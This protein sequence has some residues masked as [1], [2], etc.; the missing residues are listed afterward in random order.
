M[1]YPVGLLAAIVAAVLAG[2]GPS[3]AA[4]SSDT[5]LT[6]YSGYNGYGNIVCSIYLSPSTTLQDVNFK[7]DPYGCENDDTKSV[8]F[9]SS[10]VDYRGVQLTVFN[11]SS[12]RTTS[13]YAVT[14]IQPLNRSAR[15]NSF[16]QNFVAGSITHT[17]HY[18]SG[19][20]D[21][22]VSCIRFQRLPV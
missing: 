8:R 9:V 22:K 20:L 18:R 1:L 5:R 12:C 14:R 19:D 11:D 10:A 15:V 13:D 4:Q 7:T 17:Y 2:A 21:G 6:F 16:E 3:M